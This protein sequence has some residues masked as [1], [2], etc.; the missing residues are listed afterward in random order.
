MKWELVSF[1]YNFFC[2]VYVMY[3]L[4][5]YICNL[6]CICVFCVCIFCICLI[7]GFFLLYLCYM[8]LKVLYLCDLWFGDWLFWWLGSDWLLCWGGVVRWW[9]W[10]EF[11]FLIRS[12]IDFYFYYVV[13]CSDYLLNV[14][15][16]GLYFLCLMS[17]FKFLCFL[18]I[19]MIFVV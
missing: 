16:M 4:V 14:F 12:Y 2:I 8:C 11:F 17:C 6:F 18:K 5:F 1:E 3:V 7:C 15:L 13:F 19:N 10:W 9:I